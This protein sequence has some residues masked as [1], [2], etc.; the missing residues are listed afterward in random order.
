MGPDWH[1]LTMPRLLPTQETTFD[2]DVEGSRVIVAVEFHNL[3]HH[4]TYTRINFTKK[5]A[6][7]SFTPL[8]VVIHLQQLLL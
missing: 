3:V 4:R 6:A 2:Y 7:N 8:R 1:R 5:A